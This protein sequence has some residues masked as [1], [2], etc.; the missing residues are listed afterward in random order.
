MSK[1]PR[2]FYSNSLVAFAAADENSVLGILCNKYQGNAQTTT[3][4]DERLA[5]GKKRGSR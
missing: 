4:D 1:S 5:E 3:I 2:C